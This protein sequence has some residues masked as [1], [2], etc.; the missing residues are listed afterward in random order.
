MNCPNCGVE[1]TC[2]CQR[3][4]ASDGANCCD[5][6]IGGYQQKLQLLQIQLTIAPS[7]QPVQQLELFPAEAPTDATQQPQSEYIVKNPSSHII[8]VVRTTKP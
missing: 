4:V 8:T 2:S 7:E 1:I 3:R 6:C 5:V